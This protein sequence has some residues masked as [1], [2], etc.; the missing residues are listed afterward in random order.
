MIEKQ[1][2]FGYRTVTW[3]LGLNKNTLVSARL[4]PYVVRLNS[5]VRLQGIR[6]FD[7]GFGV[8]FEDGADGFG[9]IVD[10]V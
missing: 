10:G 1:P 4:W 9:R 5:G 6:A 3:L 8:S 2:S 7:P